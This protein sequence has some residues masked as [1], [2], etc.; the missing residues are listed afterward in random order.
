MLPLASCTGLFLIGPTMPS[1]SRRGLDHVLPASSE[2]INMPHQV[3]AM[4]DAKA[5][6]ELGAKELQAAIE[7]L[8]SE[9]DTDE[10]RSAYEKR[11]NYI[12]AAL[13][14]MGLVG[15]REPFARLFHQGWVQMGGSKMSKASMATVPPPSATR[16]RRSRPTVVLPQPDSPTRPSVSPA[17]IQKLTSSTAWT[18]GAPAANSPRLVG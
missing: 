17:R 11:R 10:M 5:R 15:F 18:A 12:C 4:K 2:V 14:D 8:R 3:R 13:N 16:R 9:A 7:A 1:G 6:L